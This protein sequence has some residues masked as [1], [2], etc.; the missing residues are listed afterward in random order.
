[1]AGKH[2]KERKPLSEVVSAKL[3]PKPDPET[4]LPFP[5]EGPVYVGPK[6][7][8]GEVRGPMEGAPPRKA[9]PLEGMGRPLAWVVRGRK[10]GIKGLIFTLCVAAV[11]IALPS[12][13]RGDGLEAW[14]V[15]QMWAVAFVG[16]WLMADPLNRETISAGADWVQWYKRPKWY[17]WRKR[18]PH[19]VKTYR[20]TNIEGY[21]AGAVLY[22]R[23]V[24]E[25][26]RGSDRIRS[27]LQPDRRIW[28]LVYNGILHSVAAGAEINSLAIDMLRLEGSPA[29]Q[30][31]SDQRD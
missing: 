17:Q 1:M 14:T 15:W 21:A 18:E 11:V 16:A 28:D 7:R 9:M 24:D 19:L 20:L 25:D 12:L 22:L 6:L 30:I 27:G 5:P 29:L 10:D 3:P 13:F 2:H 4:G 26:G 8:E 31:Q 23:V